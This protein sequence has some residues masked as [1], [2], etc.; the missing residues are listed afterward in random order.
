MATKRFKVW[1]IA[2]AGAL[3]LGCLALAGL[4]GYL[5][6]YGV[7]IPINLQTTRALGPIGG[8]GKIDYVVAIN[9]AY[10]VG[11]TPENNAAVLMLIAVGNTASGNIT[12]DSVLGPM[13]A[14]NIESRPK[15]LMM[16]IAWARAKGVDDDEVDDQLYKATEKPWGNGELGHVRLLLEENAAALE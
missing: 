16:S 14:S 5:C 6:W 12:M 9:A 7:Q 4:Y 1:L 2:I 3:G 10:C 8:D 15:P 13:G 11:V